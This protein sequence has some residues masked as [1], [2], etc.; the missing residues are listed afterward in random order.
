[1]KKILTIALVVAMMLTLAVSAFAVVDVVD[2]RASE[3]TSTGTIQVV[4]NDTTTEAEKV[5]YV[6]VDWSDSKLTYT[7][8]GTQVWDPEN[9]EYID[10]R[11]ASWSELT[12][13]VKN[14]SN[15]K[16]TATLALP[17]AKND[18]ALSEK[19]A[20]TVLTLDAAVEGTQFDEAPS[21]TYTITASGVPSVADFTVTATVTI[22]AYV[23]P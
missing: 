23:A 3:T 22:A 18:V 2:S 9:H 12:V 15:D 19:N 21:D 11:T 1:M 6:E 10:N 16:V 8:A 14:H 20:E 7:K 4:V 5:Y 13:T 17:A